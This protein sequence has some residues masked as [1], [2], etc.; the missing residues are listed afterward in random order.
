VKAAVDGLANRLPDPVPAW[1]REDLRL[2]PIADAVRT[3]HYPGSFIEAEEAAAVS[4]W[5]SSS[6]SRPPC[7][8]AAPNG[9][10]A[11]TLLPQP[12]RPPP[13][14][15]PLTA[16]AAYPR[17]EGALD[18]ILEDIRGPHPMLR[19]LQGDVGSRKTV[20]A[21]AALLAAV[22]SGYQAH[23]W[24]PPRSSPSSTTAPL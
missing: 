1:Q 3:Y 12:R 15:H 24:L 9:S 21:F 20:V 4:P 13:A 10:R 16:V 5:V 6:P 2:S 8:C 11:T 18:D 23:S 17:P 14:L 19:L 22:Q 7:S